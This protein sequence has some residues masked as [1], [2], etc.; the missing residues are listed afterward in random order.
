[1][2]LVLVNSIR[3]SMFKLLLAMTFLFS[4]VVSAQNMAETESY[5][6]AYTEMPDGSSRYVGKCS[7]HEDYENKFFGRKSLIQKY[8]SPSDLT[9][10]EMKKV[11]SKF[12]KKLINQVLSV[13]EMGDISSNYDVVSIFMDYID[14]LTVDTISHTKASG[15]DLIRFNVGI[16]GGNGGYLIFSKVKN[17]AQY[18]LMS[19]T[20]DS[21]LNFCDKKVWL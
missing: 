8:I 6:E 15:L 18:E 11:L 17:K 4:G 1:M 21:D 7:T 10:A 9:P 20:L 12:D 2:E 14:D 19:Y 16:G 13:L 3:G 5:D